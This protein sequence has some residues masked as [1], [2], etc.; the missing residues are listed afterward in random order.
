MTFKTNKI[1]PFY[2]WN[3]FFIDGISLLLKNETNNNYFSVVANSYLVAN[4]IRKSQKPFRTRKIRISKTI[5]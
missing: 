5:V 1:K 2:S 3:G 4:T